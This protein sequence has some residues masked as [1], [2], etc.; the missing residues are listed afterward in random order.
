MVIGIVVSVAS[1]MVLARLLLDRGE[2]HSA[3]GRVMIGITLVEDLAV[4]VLT[5]V[6]GAVGPL[7]AGRLFGAA[8]ALF[9]SIVVLIPFAYLAAGSFRA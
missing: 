1:T 9:I 7:E 8:R 5:V 3:H 2:L 6:L 4:V